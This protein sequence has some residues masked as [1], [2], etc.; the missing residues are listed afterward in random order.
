MLSEATVHPSRID[1][2]A[3]EFRSRTDTGGHCRD[4]SGVC[5]VLIL[6]R[7]SH[8]P[9]WMTNIISFDTLHTNGQS[10]RRK[11]TI[12]RYKGWRSGDYGCFDIFQR[13][14]KLFHSLHLLYVMAP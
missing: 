13:P 10:L 12:D 1:A 5:G 14:T 11:W 7:M 3:G 9:P 8:N 4:V 2:R 6:E